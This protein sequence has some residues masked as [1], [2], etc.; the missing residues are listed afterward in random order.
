MSQD[1][2]LERIARL[3][4]ADR[5][6][7]TVELDE[8]LAALD[9][10]LADLA[11]ALEVAYVG[12]GV[13]MA[14]M[15]AEHVYRLVVRRHVWDTTTAGWGLKVCDALDNNDLR[16]MWPIQGVGRL[17][18][19]QVVK[20]LPAFFAGYAEAVRAAGKADT[21]AGRRILAMAGKLS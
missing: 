6:P 11:G 2:P 21:E 10:E 19:Q 12:P 15:G 20:A 1:D 4:H 5:V 14:D 9:A 18:K 13:G 16:P 7:V 17:R 8:A 3:A